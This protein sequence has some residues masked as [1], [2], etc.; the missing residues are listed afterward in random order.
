MAS[1]TEA[2]EAA[3]DIALGKCAPSAP[4]QP[5]AGTEELPTW[6][7][8]TLYEVSRSPVQ[9]QHQRLTC[10]CKRPAYFYRTRRDIMRTN[11]C[12]RRAPSARVH[13]VYRRQQSEA[14]AWPGCRP[15]LTAQLFSTSRYVT[16][17][18]V[19]C[20]RPDAGNIGPPKC[21]PYPLKLEGTSMS[22]SVPRCAAGQ[23]GVRR[24]TTSS[25]IQP[26]ELV[27]REGRS[28]WV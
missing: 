23:A 15:V 4:R 10:L 18:R 9:T 14:R 11:H 26:A 7:V 20:R 1:R 28:S 21:S 6:R 8:L 3:R 25:S 22:H 13:H 12:R 27:D 19:Q 16:M 24:F 17:G 2:N 5:Q